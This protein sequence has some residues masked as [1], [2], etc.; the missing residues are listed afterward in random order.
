MGWK[1]IEEKKTEQRTDSY[2]AGSINKYQM[3]RGNLIRKFLF[4]SDYS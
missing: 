3:L 1:P 4:F 2:T